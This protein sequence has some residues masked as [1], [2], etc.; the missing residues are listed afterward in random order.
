MSAYVV[1]TV[2]IEDPALYEEYRPV[3][4]LWFGGGSR[5]VTRDHPPSNQGA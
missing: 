5:P 4:P 2:S 3:A 1:V